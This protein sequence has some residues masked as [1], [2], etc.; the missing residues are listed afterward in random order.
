MKRT[1]SS[2]TEDEEFFHKRGY[3]QDIGFGDRPAVIVIDFANAFTDP[4]NNL[5]SNL[6]NEIAAA[7]QVLD[8]AREHSVPI[9]FTTVEY[10]EVKSDGFDDVWQRKQPSRKTLKAGSHNVQID[11]RLGR[12]DSERLVPKR[13]ASAYFGTDLLPWLIARSIDTVI[14]VGCSTSGCVRA[15]AVDTVQ[16]GLRPIIVKEAVGD[17]SQNAHIQALFDLRQKYADVVSVDDV[18]SYLSSR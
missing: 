9:T 5:G 11:V 18:I 12:R 13:Y 6:D 10:E 2:I 14:I 1:E 15:T 3:G 4:A 8:K 16:M 17:R 7:V